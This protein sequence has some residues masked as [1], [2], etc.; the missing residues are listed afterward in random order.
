MHYSCL[1]SI[2]V[3][4]SNKSVVRSGSRISIMMLY[5]RLYF[6]LYMNTFNCSLLLFELFLMA[7]WTVVEL[8]SLSL[9][10]II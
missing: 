3:Q 10:T 6:I 5:F 1:A 4:R 7:Y 2:C 9:H 8:L